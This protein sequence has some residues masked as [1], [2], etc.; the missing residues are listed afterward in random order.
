MTPHG[1]PGA[2][3]DASERAGGGGVARWATQRASEPGEVFYFY[4]I[5]ILCYILFGFYFKT[6]PARRDRDSQEGYQ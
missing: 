3:S 4:L 5:F 2:L 6:E 1:A